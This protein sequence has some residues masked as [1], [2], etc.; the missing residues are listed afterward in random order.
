MSDR[1]KKILLIV[2]FILVILLIGFA[3]YYFLFRPLIVPTPTPVTPVVPPITGLPG[4][5]PAL[6]VPIPAVNLPVGVPQL[7]TIPPST[8]IPGPT[9]SYVAEGGITGYTTLFSEAT[10]N[11]TL[12]AN[13]KD[14]LYYD[15]Q[16]GF[17]YSITPDGEK[18][19]YSD[20][21]FK[22]V[23]NVTWSNNTQKAVLEYNDGSKAIYDFSQKKSVT[24]PS[25]WKDFTFS[26]DSNQI[27]FK[28]M[29]VDPE[30]RYIAIADTNAGNYQQIEPIGT[31]DADVYIT[32]SPNNKYVALYRESIDGDRAEVYPIGFNGENF[33]NFR[34][35]GRD[36]RF[37]WSPSGN[38]LVYSVFNSRSDYNPSLWVTNS[39][40]DLLGTGRTSLEIKTW[41]D[42]CVFA[43]EATIYCA[44]PKQLDSGTGFRPDLADNTPD[45][46]YAINVQTGAKALLAQPLFPTT[47]NKL[48]VSEDK[49]TLYWWEKNTDQIKEIKLP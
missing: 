8:L 22:N 3:I 35:E 27:A 46:I 41:A 7:P 2:G 9:L 47:I 21:A 43:S 42:K 15:K 45:E 11:P 48:I 23:S 36:L 16:T 25:Q 13:G 18:K 31:K 34:V 28:N 37:A 19:L 26:N 29:R 14:L 40:P 12:A 6:N 44:V 17:F 24:L 4:I 20:I 30:N 49:K 5:L 1:T 39:D 33:K 32:W 10:L 38:K